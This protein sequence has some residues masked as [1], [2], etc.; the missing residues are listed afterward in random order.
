MYWPFSKTILI[1]YYSEGF[2]LVSG[3]PPKTKGL[4]TKYYS[5]IKYY[6]EP[7]MVDFPKGNQQFP[8]K[9]NQPRNEGL[10]HKYYSDIKY[11]FGF[12]R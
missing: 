1:K 4:C 3:A 11:Y 12:L 10:L 7:E 2:V 8:L 9:N 5:D 6:S